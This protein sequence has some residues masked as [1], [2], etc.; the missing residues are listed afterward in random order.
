[1]KVIRIEDMYKGWFVGNFEP[2]LLQTNHIEVAVKEYRKGDYEELHHHKLA[3]EITV[4]NSG[5]VKM[6]GVEYIKGDIIIVQANQATDF[7]VIE[8]TIT[9]VVK[10]PSVENDKYLGDPY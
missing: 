2:T 1:M 5:K 9:T 4:I 6:N 3:T 10:F 8:D 7:V